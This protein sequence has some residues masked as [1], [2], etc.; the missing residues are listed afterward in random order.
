MARCGYRKLQKFQRHKAAWDRGQARIPLAYLEGIGVDLD[1]LRTAVELDQRALVAAVSVPLLPRYFTAR[2]MAAVYQ[3]T[4]LPEGCTEEQAVEM[5]RR[6]AAKSGRECCIHF[7]G[8]K[9]VF[10]RPDGSVSTCLY[11]PELR[12]DNGKVSFGET[13]DALG[14]VG[15]R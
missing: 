12:I 3:T 5:V 2:L 11:K 6:F 15:V 13:G 8:L 10:I 9:S 4:E 14:M 7:P 1:L